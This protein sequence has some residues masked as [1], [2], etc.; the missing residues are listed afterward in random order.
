MSMLPKMICVLPTATP[1]ATPHEANSI[2]IVST[3]LYTPLIVFLLVFVDA[4]F[5]YE[6]SIVIVLVD[7]LDLSLVFG[8]ML[9]DNCCFH[10]FLFDGRGERWR[11]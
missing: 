3:L 10:F 5:C 8:V 1:D 7:I 11:W 6:H 9:L 2:E 4:I